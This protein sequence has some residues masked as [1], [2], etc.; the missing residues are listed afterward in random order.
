MHSVHVFIILII[1][2]LFYP[3]R[4]HICLEIRFSRNKIVVI[5][6]FFLK[7]I[8]LKTKYWQNDIPLVWTK[9]HTCCFVCKW[10]L[11]NLALHILSI[12]SHNVEIIQELNSSSVLDARQYSSWNFPNTSHYNEEKCSHL[13][14]KDLFS[15]SRSGRGWEIVGIGLTVLEHMFLDEHRALFVK[16]DQ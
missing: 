7:K 15:R 4:I 14:F 3:L 8:S 5:F 10:Y 16:L 2:C 12:D 13:Y 6:V 1:R 9:L 11:F